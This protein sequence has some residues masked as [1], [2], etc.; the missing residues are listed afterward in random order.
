MKANSSCA[1]VLAAASMIANAAPMP[2]TYRVYFGTTAGGGERGIYMAL[3]DTQTGQLGEAAHVSN[4]VRPGFIVIHPD[5]K[6]LYATEATGSAPAGESGAV[7]AYRIE[8]DGMLT[9]LNTQPSGGEGPCYIS[10]D[11]TGKQLLVANYGSGSCAVLPI[12]PDGTL[13]DPTA[14]R[15][16]SGSGPN[17][18]RQEAAHTH[19]FNCDPS[20]QFALAADLGID[21]ILIYH[22]SNGTLAPNIPSVIQTAPGAGP[23]HLTFSPNGK[24]VYTSM[25][26][27]GTVSAYAY[28]A[29][30]LTEIQTL[31]TLPTNFDG[32][33]TVS[34]V[35]LT[36]DGRFLYVGNRGHESL[37]VFGVDLETGKL[38]AL[39][40]EPTRGNHPRHFNIDPT[41]QFLIAANLY[42]NNAVVFRINQ[43]TGQ[44]EFT[45][46]EITVP[47]ATCVQFFSHTP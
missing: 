45:G 44:L 27:N 11:P 22:L 46:S 18:E 7:S 40:H 3:F 17:P 6:H 31:P 12:L 34:E 29:G 37:A 4:S 8:A 33:N 2:D 5:G 20:G 41:G 24:F 39:G 10:I 9:D 26:L 30:A 25:E 38:T 1:S 16:H 23:R 42:S 14:I 35:R 47:A 13:G 15:R 21:T 43:E 28:K 36:P 19:S 32:Y